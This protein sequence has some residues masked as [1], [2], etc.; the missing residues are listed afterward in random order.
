[1]LK[2][3]SSIFIFFTFLAPLHA[4]LVS[5]DEVANLRSATILMN[6]YASQIRLKQW[7]S[8]GS[9]FDEKTTAVSALMN[10]LERPEHTILHSSKEYMEFLKAT[11]LFAEIMQAEATDFM[12]DSEAQIR[13]QHAIA[14]EEDL[15]PEVR[16]LPLNCLILSAI[17][18]SHTEKEKK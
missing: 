2:T 11:M 7:S 14:T 15:P 8:L 13:Y 3:L 1:M 17:L 10:R 12:S 4:S 9:Y 5:D 16:T 6:K 18:P